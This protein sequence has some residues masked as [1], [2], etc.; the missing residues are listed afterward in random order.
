MI[1]FVP[2][3]W[4]IE[5]AIWI[6][7]FASIGVFSFVAGSIIP[8]MI[9]LLIDRFVSQQAG[10]TYGEVIQLYQGLTRFVFATAIAEVLIF[11]FLKVS[12]IPGLKLS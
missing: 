6:V 8:W 11:L 9:R 7:F 4:M 12:A 1:D 2:D 3:M 10:E 5:L